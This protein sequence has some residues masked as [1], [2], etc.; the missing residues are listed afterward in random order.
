MKIAGSPNLDSVKFTSS[1]INPDDSFNDRLVLD[2]FKRKGL[3][4]IKH[5]AL[6][7][8]DIKNPRSARPPSIALALESFKLET[9][10]FH[11]MY[12]RGLLP[13]NASTLTSFSI[14]LR[15]FGLDDIDAILDYVPETLE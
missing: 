12:L 1:L 2:A 5:L 15:Y 10:H 3:E 14:S 7:D 8:V 13:S 4:G 6:G 9:V 11:F